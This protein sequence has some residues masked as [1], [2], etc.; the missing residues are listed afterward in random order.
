MSGQGSA[1][2][3]NDQQTHSGK[4]SMACDELQADNGTVGERGGM[5]PNISKLTLAAV[6][7]RPRR[8][9]QPKIVSPLQRGLFKSGKS[10][11]GCIKEKNLEQRDWIWA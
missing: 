5:G 10:F 1:D 6:I 8:A 9:K 11:C 7:G 2:L 4:A 3:G